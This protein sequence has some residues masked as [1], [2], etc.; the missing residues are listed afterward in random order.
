MA[1]TST[2]LVMKAHSIP[3]AG[4]ASLSCRRRSVFRPGKIREPG[5]RMIGKPPV[6]YPKD[7]NH[8]IAVRRK[9]SLPGQVPDLSRIQSP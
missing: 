2:G 5:P 7:R 9:S 3:A 8:P 4:Y 1:R 6:Y